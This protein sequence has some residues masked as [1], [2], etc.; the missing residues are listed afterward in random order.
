MNEEKTPDPTM[1]KEPM[2]SELTV[3]LQQLGDRISRLEVKLDSLTRLVKRLTPEEDHSR[4]SS[5]PTPLP[6]QKVRVQQPTAEPGKAQR[7]HSD[8]WKKKG[9]RLFK[10][11]RRGT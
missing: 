11:E 3:K 1:S 8:R 6:S 4:S 7:R 9:A 10:R 5:H 2:S